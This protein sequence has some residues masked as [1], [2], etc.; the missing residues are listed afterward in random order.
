MIDHL[1]FVQEV[2]VIW[3]LTIESSIGRSTCGKNSLNEL[4]AVQR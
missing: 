1:V 3:A 4:E 2:D